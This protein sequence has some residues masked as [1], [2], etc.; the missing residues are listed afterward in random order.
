LSDN[1][2]RPSDFFS[3]SAPRRLEPVLSRGGDKPAPRPATAAAAP[4][5][6]APFETDAPAAPTAFAGAPQLLV[7]LRRLA[8]F[9]R[10][11]DAPT[12]FAIGL[13]SAAGGG[14]T[15]AFNW[16]TNSLAAP[17][18]PPVVK[19]RAD[20]LADE[21]ER[22][23][24]AALY[25]ALSPLYGP[26]AQEAAEDGAHRSADAGA[27]ARAAN[28]K[29]D[30]LRK[31]LVS[32]QENLAQ[33]EARRAALA[34]TL[35]YETPGAR[36]DAYAR[37]QRGAFESRLRR[38][39]F[40]GD[41]L[42]GFKD[43]VRDL[44][45]AGGFFPRL[46][47]AL[48]AIYAYRGQTRLLVFS[49]LSFGLMWGARWL[50]ANKALWLAVLAG[51]GGVG[52]QTA[53]YLRGHIGWLPQASQIF[54]LLGLL[55]LALNFWRAFAFMQPLLHAAGLLDDEVEAKRHE[56][57][58]TLAHQVHSVDL[59]GV[60][61]AT[62][63]RQASESERRASAAGASQQP[64]L[65]LESDPAAQKR[66]VAR[67]FLESLSERIVHGKQGFAPARLIVA[68]DGFE[69][70]AAPAAAF[71]RLHD[72]LAR[73]GFVA[74]YALDPDA[75]GLT[76][77]D[78]ARRLQLPLRID[79]GG[80]EETTA[81]APLGAALSQAE[82]QL[83]GALE[84]VAG[85]TFRARKR[86]RNFYRFLRP[87]EEASP[88]LRAALALVLAGGLSASP[89]DRRALHQA[90]ANEGNELAP[91]AG[92]PQLREAL[93]NFAAAAGPISRDET[94]RAAALARYVGTES[95]V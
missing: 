15:S 67:G 11:A 76:P 77:A 66:A 45:E 57:D 36:V 55:L 73:P 82:T 94:L 37:R 32:E 38:F 52:P 47:A 8:E 3:A 7:L 81:L 51:S 92:S 20:E 17:D 27:A 4:A 33:T 49:A 87:A 30:T 85:E 83:I 84:P 44:V 22:A 65:F 89:D 18:A 28:E 56:L 62:A 90:V 74:V 63:A 14:K 60:E 19:L 40:A 50:A 95:R 54:A 1:E 91:H 16:L 21:P 93:A 72:L 64:P 29:L 12:P 46:G 31:R 43:R 80:G 26:L 59:L 79:A 53:D 48:R 24:G 78:L 25:R 5:A 6:A 35:L 39:G 71:D 10:R 68:I 61:V 69:R 13:L 70:C 58:K 86:F 75:S 41:P 34:E 2:N 88:G 9:L 23:L 42:H